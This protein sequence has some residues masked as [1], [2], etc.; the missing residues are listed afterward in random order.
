MVGAC[1][2]AALPG[3]VGAADP[4]K[5]IEELRRRVSALET[6]LELMELFVKEL[7]QEVNRLRAG[8]TVASTSP[9]AQPDNPTRTTPVP[10]VTPVREAPRVSK[11]YGSA[12]DMMRDLPP[13]LQPVAGKGWDAARLS[14]VKEWMRRSMNGHRFRGA[15]EVSRVQLARNPKG[16]E[17]GQDPWHVTFF[18]EPQRME[19]EGVVLMQKV[20]DLWP[21]P[22]LI[23]GNEEYARA[24]SQVGRGTKVVVQGE[25]VAVTLGALVGEHRDCVIQLRGYLVEAP[26]FKPREPAA[27]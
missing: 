17:E 1:W 10:P 27:P 2:L 13:S 14:E 15:M 25:V 26:Q 12:I 20:A 3:S 19:Y 5:E 24:A 6:R 22:L 11:E 9:A 21:Q 18:F 4:Q 8:G 16:F 7:K 23:A